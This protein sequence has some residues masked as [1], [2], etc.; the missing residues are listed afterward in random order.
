MPEVRDR[1]RPRRRRLLRGLA[2]AGV[3]AG[4]AG[5]VTGPGDGGGDGGDG[6]ST[7]TTSA[8]PTTTA[9]PAEPGGGRF[10]DG[11]TQ[12]AQG[13][14]DPLAVG[15]Q[16][17][18]NRLNLLYDPGGV[19]DDDPIGFQGRLLESWELGE[20]A[21]T[22]R[23]RVR[24]GLEW[25]AGY[26]ALTAETYLYNVEHVFTAGWAGYTQAQFFSL[27]GEPIEYEQ[28]GEHTFEAHLPAPRA[29]FLHE[30][31]LIPA[32]L[33][34]V[35]LLE[36]HGARDGDDST[37]DALARDPDVRQA[38]IVGNLGP[39][40][41]DVFEQGSR[42]AVSANPDYYLAETDVGDGAYRDT[43]KVDG[44]R[45]QVFGE[46]STVYA[47]LKAGDVTST[48]IEARRKAEFEAT[49]GV[50]VWSSPYGNGLFWVSLN[51]RANGWAP[52]RESRAV[53]RALAH[54]L[55]VETLIGDIFDGNANP[56]DTM[57]PRWGPYYSESGITRY[58]Y[59]PERA[60][61]LLASGTSADYG[62][63]GSGE[64][65]GP[66][67][68]QVTLRFVTRSDIQTGQLVASFVRQALREAGLAVE[69]RGLRFQDIIGTY[70]A[71]S[72]GNNPDFDGEPAWT[73]GP[74]NGGRWDQAVS[75]EPWDLLF[76]IGLSGSIAYAPW[77]AVDAM[78]TERGSFNAF[79]YHTDEYD[80]A[81]AIAAAAG[82][83]TR[84]AATDVLED[85][86]GFLSADVPHLW[87]H[88]NHVIRGYRSEVS[89]LPEPR[90]FFSV[91]EQ[92]GRPDVRLIAL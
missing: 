51:H 73:A 15:D 90:N 52:I 75:A 56:I 61:S 24:D 3:A 63:T 14:I 78:I 5:C 65:V 68:E 48:G 43:P 17:T 29:N 82:A 9:T 1:Y 27:D 11:T 81:D 83:D 60:R 16:A 28:T 30:D 74:F 31:P 8:G 50:D 2:A 85:L 33:L 36:K 76:G 91:D 44:V 62:Y 72:V 42:M 45:T 13:G 89:G 66:D 79:G 22:V 46:Q 58:P 92:T 12:A 34:P 77:Q 4:L 54:L 47:A 39:F 64:F 86:F 18:L 70:L 69:V 23:Y 88:N 19:I 87:T 7:G 25:G 37:R 35:G 6:G 53:R 80:F 26:G 84:S 71:N 20:D 32:Y 41:L 10:V 59:D 67:G 49:D 40:T 38:N 57:H 55:D 21:R